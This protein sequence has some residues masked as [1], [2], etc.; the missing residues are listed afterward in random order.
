MFIF[1]YEIAALP[2]SK[3]KKKEKN[4]NNNKKGYLYGCA[5]QILR[6][7]FSKMPYFHPS[8]TAAWPISPSVPQMT[9]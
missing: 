1:S 9:L 3:K 5:R 4:N 2:L 6:M 8:C 7:L